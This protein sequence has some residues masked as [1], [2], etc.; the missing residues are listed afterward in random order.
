MCNWCSDEPDIV[1]TGIGKKIPVVIFYASL[2]ES[3]LKERILLTGMIY[4]WNAC[5]TFVCG[6]FISA[7]VQDWENRL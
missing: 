6:R 3:E 2:L 5:A 4:K 1:W 7:D